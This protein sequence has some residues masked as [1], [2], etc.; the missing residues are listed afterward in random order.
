MTAQSHPNY[1]IVLW[2]INLLAFK[3]TTM[4]ML[5]AIL[6]WLNGWNGVAL[7]LANREYVCVGVC[8]LWKLLLMLVAV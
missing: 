3:N 5:G 2:H 6:S 8:L 7:A 4:V 1:L